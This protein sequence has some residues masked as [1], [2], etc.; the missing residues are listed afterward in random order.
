MPQPQFISLN[1]PSC[2][3]SLRVS[4]GDGP[5]IRYTCDYCGNQHL[6]TVAD[7]GRVTASGP[8][9]AAGMSP[10]AAAQAATPIRPLV[11][12]PASVQVERDGQT[13]RIRQRWF[14]FKYVILAIFSVFW[15]GFLLFWYSMAFGSMAFGGS[16][17]LIMTLFPLL[18]VLVGVT[19]TY[20]ALTGLVNHTDLEISP[21]EL[22]VRFGP[23]PWLGEKTLPAAD[24]RQVYCKEKVTRREDGN[25]YSYQFYALLQDGRAVRLIANIE[26]ADTALFFE[27]QVESWLRLA[28][29]PVQGAYQG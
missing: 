17:S 23:L 26:S 24:I 27:Q 9:P 14:S 10:A 21:L 8:A 12:Q 7:A 13:L 11:D 1:C 2:G 22:A 19:I 4:A 25:T 18:H 5:Y 3:A 20:S 6:L 29:Q 28:D 16:A 15:D